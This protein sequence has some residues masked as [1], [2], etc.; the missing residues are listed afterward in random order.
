M[1][2]NTFPSSSRPS[3]VSLL[4]WDLKRQPELDGPVINTCH[5]RSQ[6]QKEAAGKCETELG[7]VM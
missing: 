2:A 4:L 1:L 7:L 6:I 3:A 5:K